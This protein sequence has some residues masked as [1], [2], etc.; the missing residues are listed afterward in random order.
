MPD[1]N[2]VLISGFSVVVL[3]LFL[4][5]AFREAFPAID[6]RFLPLVS[7]FVG[8]GLVT[9]ANYAPSDVT[10]TVATGIAVGA[11]ASLS[12]R[13][14]KN[15]DSGS[16]PVVTPLQSTFIQGTVAETAAKPVEAAPLSFTNLSKPYFS[17]ITPASLNTFG[18][19]V[20]GI[21]EAN[22]RGEEPRLVEAQ[23]HVTVTMPA[24]K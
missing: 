13:Y 23:P 1:L 2:G 9:L 16:V 14:V 3:V 19:T 10:K 22:P 12:V 17:D 8:G 6:S 4:V 20:Q 18:A 15:G 21:A 24:T 11:A 7:L 5:Q